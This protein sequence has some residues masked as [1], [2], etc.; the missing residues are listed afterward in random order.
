MRYKFLSLIILLL[1]Y[2]SNNNVKAQT[3]IT[4]FESG[5]HFTMMSRLDATDH[6]AGSLGLETEEFSKILNLGIGGRITFNLTRNFALE[7]EYNFLPSKSP[8]TGNKR[9]WFYGLKSG[10]RKDKF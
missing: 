7:T 1:F 10:I 4:R 9:E 3:E 5:F 8:Y 2:N 6:N